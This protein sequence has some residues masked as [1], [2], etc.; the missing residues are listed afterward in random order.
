MKI[1][2][3]S[4]SLDKESSMELKINNV[5]LVIKHND[6]GYSIDT[7]IYEGLY[8]LDEVLIRDEQVFFDDLEEVITNFPLDFKQINN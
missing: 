4:I 8:D 5:K 2:K 1:D 7:Y 3:Y 6:I